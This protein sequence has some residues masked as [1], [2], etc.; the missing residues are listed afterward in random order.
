MKKKRENETKKQKKKIIADCSIIRLEAR[1]K[2][3]RN[4]WRA[5]KSNHDKQSIHYFHFDDENSAE[6]TSPFE[7]FFEHLAANVE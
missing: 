2:R 4:R 5:L 3:E 1:T 6:E 7:K